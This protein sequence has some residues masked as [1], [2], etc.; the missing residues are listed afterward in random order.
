[1]ANPR[2]LCLT[3]NDSSAYLWYADSRLDT[4]QG[5]L[6]GTIPPQRAVSLDNSLVVE[7]E[8]QKW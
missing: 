6:H 2:P 3:Y 7:M 8:K 5:T 4:G 1:M